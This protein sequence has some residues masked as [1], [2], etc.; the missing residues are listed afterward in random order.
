MSAY[1]KPILEIA[2]VEKILREHL[3]EDVVSIEPIEGGNLSSVFAFNYGGKGYIIKFS[4]MQGAYETEGFVLGLLTS[5]GVPFPRYLGRGKVGTL[6]YSIL[7]R[8]TGGILNDCSEMEKHRMLPELMQILAQMNQINLGET[9]GLGWIGPTGNGSF[10]TWK[11]YITSFFAED[12][13][14]AFWEGWYDLFHTTC[15]EK[16]IFDECY[17][18]LMMFSSFNEPHRYFIHGDFQPWNILSDGQRITGI[19]DGNFAYGDFM[20]DIATLV[21]TMGELDVV[22]AYKE[23]YKKMGIVIPNFKERL[24]G[25]QYFKGLDGLRFYAKMGWN[26]AYNQLRN[27]L[28]N[29]TN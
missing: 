5:Q 22:Q 28:I 2:E 13:T 21:G 29:L 27:F 25:A 26:D 4:D 8:I 18:R 7:E 10:G 1:E 24:I 14:G 12:Q 20:I 15:L 23:Q 3:K 17:N 6:T 11:E 16:D 9:S 19:I